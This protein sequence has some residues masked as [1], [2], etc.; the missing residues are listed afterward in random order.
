MSKVF[1]SKGL[2]EKERKLQAKKANT[3]KKK[4]E[5]NRLRNKTVAFRVTEEEKK[6]LDA[7]IESSGLLKQDY[8]IQA[9]MSHSVT[10][11]GSPKMAKGLSERLDNILLELKKLRSISEVTEEQ[12]VYIEKMMELQEAIYYEK[13]KSL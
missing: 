13:E 5:S 11:F 12:L 9:L 10:Y 1:R 8:I 6:L 4:N 7:L 3:S 2:R